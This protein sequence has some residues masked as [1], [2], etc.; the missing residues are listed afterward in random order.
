MLFQ[1]LDNKRECYA[2]YCDGE[3]Y[4]YPN[5]L[6][7][8]ETWDWSCHV[9]SNVD[10][11]QVWTNGKSLKEVCPEHMQERLDGVQKRGLAFFQAL[12]KAKVSL[13]DVCFYEL[14]PKNFLL[15]HCRIKN[16]ISSHVF[17]TYSK[18]KNY[19]FQINLLGMLD[20]ISKRSLKVSK[21]A[22]RNL[23]IH[24]QKK[25]LQIKSLS[26]IE[27]NPWGSVTGRLTTRKDS[28]PILTLP[29]TLR[30][31]IEPNNDLFL[32]LDYNSAEMRVALAAAGQVQ[33]N[34]DIHEH[35]REEVYGQKYTR[36]DTKQKVFAWLYNPAARSKKLSEYINKDDILDK[37][38]L[39]GAVSTAFDRRIEVH[40][41]KALNYLIQ[42]TTSDMFL[43]Q[44]IKIDKLLEGTNSEVAFCIH[45]SLVIDM[46]KADKPLLEKIISMFKAT[47]FGEFRTNVSIGKNF[48][49]M[50]QVE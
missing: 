29:K 39:G 26:G 11:A 23:N 42:S 27:Y 49:T 24:E 20:K 3:L 18:P 48:G 31:V 50:R 15:D 6:S 36:D 28:F 22:P 12:Q 1:T 16:D 2:I 43:R 19:D 44:A 10:C 34:I 33:P 8:T 35:L 25:Y 17:Q 47:P 41:D 32:E 9:P 30:Q 14:V 21:K 37:H 38:Y 5:N 45:D 46:S 13:N 4:H 40:R 7:L